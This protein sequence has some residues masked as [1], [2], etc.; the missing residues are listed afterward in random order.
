MSKKSPELER[1]KK[2]ADKAKAE[3]WYAQYCQENGLPL[4]LTGRQITMAARKKAR[5][6]PKEKRQEVLDAFRSGQKTVKEIA[7]NCGVTI[8]ELIGVVIINTKTI[9]YTVLNEISV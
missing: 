4:P 9:K 1:L 7:E 6:L 8:D 5:D 3:F 2:K